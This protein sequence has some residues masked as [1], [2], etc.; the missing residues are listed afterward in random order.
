MTYSEF[1]R[2]FLE[3]FGV[4]AKRWSGHQVFSDMLQMAL[5]CHHAT[6][7]ASLGTVKDK[8]NSDMFLKAKARYSQEEFDT[9]LYL[10]L[11]LKKF[12]MTYPHDDLLGEVYM[13]LFGDRAKRGQFFT[14]K[15]VCILMAK[16]SIDESN[17][18]K[19]ST[20]ADPACGSGR[21]L[22]QVAAI[23]PGNYFFANDVDKDCA[24]MTVFNFFLNGMRAEV[25]WGNSLT[26]DYQKVWQV[27]GDLP[28]IV[29]VLLED[30]IAFN[31]KK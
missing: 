19:E 7:V 12:A 21:T 6:L 1:Q 28:G 23:A 31:V 18:P 22:L 2:D 30:S 11:L 9:L 14:P 26:L 29:P 16:M 27:N 25:A 24:M 17:P 15:D 5:C 10:I 13:E 3:M 4:L 20:I 8:A